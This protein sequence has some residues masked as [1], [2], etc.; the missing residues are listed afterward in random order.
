MSA[1]LSLPDL[2]ARGIELSVNGEKLRYRAP[3]GIITADVLAAL[4]ASKPQ[5]IAEL[6]REALTEDATEYVVEREA[7]GTADGLP[8]AMLRPVYTCTLRGNRPF[9][10]LGRVGETLEQARAE[11]RKQFGS[12]LVDLCTRQPTPKPKVVA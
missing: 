1:V 2:K 6:H 7:I 10:V 12:D 3:A 4:K 11:L 9:I 8:P 5:L